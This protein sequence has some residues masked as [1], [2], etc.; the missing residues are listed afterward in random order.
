MAFLSFLVHAWF[1]CF[2]RR[3]WVLVLTAV[4]LSDRNAWRRLCAVC[5]LVVSL[6]LCADQT[7]SSFFPLHP[8]QQVAGET[9][10]DLFLEQREAELKQAMEDKRKRQLAVPGIINPHDLPD[11]MQT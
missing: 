1:T 11:E 2:Q 7:A 3:K 10:A 5:F 6:I 4:V 8:K 9:S